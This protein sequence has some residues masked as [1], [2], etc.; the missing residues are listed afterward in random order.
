MMMSSLFELC[1]NW[2]ELPFVWI[3]FVNG[4]NYIDWWLWF[5]IFSVQIIC[6]IILLISTLSTCMSDG[7]FA[8]LIIQIISMNF[9]KLYLYNLILCYVPLLL[10]ICFIWHLVCSFLLSQLIVFT[11]FFH[12][13]GARSDHK[14]HIVGDRPHRNSTSWLETFN[15]ISTC[16]TSGPFAA[17]WGSLKHGTCHG[18]LHRNFLVTVSLPQI[19]PSKIQRDGVFLS[20]CKQVQYFEVRRFSRNSWESG[21]DVDLDSVAYGFMASQALAWGSKPIIVSPHSFHSTHCAF[22]KAMMRLFSLV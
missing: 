15:V 4:C 5:S 9:A 18:C 16:E 3:V 10:L 11:L 1:M 12:V 6:C 8:N 20:Q 21:D 17:A 22:A 7:F 19:L 14:A 13:G 2:Y